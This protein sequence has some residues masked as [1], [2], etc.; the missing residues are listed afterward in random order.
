MILSCVPA[1][2]E[3]RPVLLEHP[4]ARPAGSWTALGL[5]VRSSLPAGG[6]D[7]VKSRGA[8]LFSEIA[9]I[10]IIDR[11]RNSGHR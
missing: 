9:K 6:Q 10:I 4:P 1:Q 3:Q 11:N 8:D 2:A 5:C 7:G